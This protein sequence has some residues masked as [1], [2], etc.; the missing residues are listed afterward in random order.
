MIINYL[1][2]NIN[3]NERVF[4]I[5]DESS[6]FIICPVTDIQKITRYGGI[7]YE[8]YQSWIPWPA[9]IN[10]ELNYAEWL[11]EQLMNISDVHKLFQYF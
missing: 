9:R 6:P 4:K 8:K 10:N 3:L 2:L 7:C 11:Y 5:F 1:L